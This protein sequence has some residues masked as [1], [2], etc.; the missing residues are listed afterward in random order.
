MKRVLTISLTTLLVAVGCSAI[1]LAQGTSQQP[2]GD[3]ARAIKK[4]KSAPAPSAQ[5]VYDNDNLPTAASVSVVGSS[6]STDAAKTDSKAEETSSATAASDKKEEPQVKPGQSIDER[7]QALDAWKQKLEDQNVKI[8][9]LSHELDILQREYRV[10]AAEF[11]A[12]TARRTQNPTG[13]AKED[14][15][16][17]QKIA[18]KQKA[19][20]DAKTKLSDL[21]EQA[22]KAGAPS[23]VAD[24][25]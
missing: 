16:Y 7:K 17:K 21:Q 24:Q 14:A 11:Y 6:G 4:S 12:D 15:D 3:Y 23:S 5:K 2:L 8:G 10:K 25:N 19:V 9:S 20:D 13:F 22:R 18:D 1:A